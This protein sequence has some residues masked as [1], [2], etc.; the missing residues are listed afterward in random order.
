MFAKSYIQP[1]KNRLKRLNF[2]VIVSDKTLLAGE[3]SEYS[4]E[5]TIQN[6]LALTTVSIYSNCIRFIIERFNRKLS[7]PWS[8]SS[9]I[10]ILV[11]KLLVKRE[12][13]N[14]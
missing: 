10:P 3:R 7:A 6:I 2:P 12:T 11:P 13:S 9:A 4:V 14:I 8:I 1:K 5:H